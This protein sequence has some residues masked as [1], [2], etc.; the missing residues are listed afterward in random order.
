MALPKR[1][2]SALAA[3][4]EMP[5]HR[6]QA[7]TQ[8]APRPEEVYEVNRPHVRDSGSVAHEPVGE[9]E[10]PHAEDDEGGVEAAAR[11][12]FRG[13]VHGGVSLA[14][15]ASP[16]TESTESPTSIPVPPPLALFLPDCYGKARSG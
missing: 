1:A 13:A 9:E 3:V 16:G 8:A 10:E 6:H 12:F 2:A 4:G 14:D 7:R 11:P 15:V 5:D